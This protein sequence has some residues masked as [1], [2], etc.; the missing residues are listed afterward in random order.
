MEFEFPVY[1]N[2]FLRKM[3]KTKIICKEETMH[4]VKAIFQETLL[5]PL[6][7]SNVDEDFVDDYSAKPDFKKEG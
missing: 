6:D 3:T 2:F 7:F 5:G 4:Q 1:Y